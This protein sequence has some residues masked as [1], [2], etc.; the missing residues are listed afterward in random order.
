MFQIKKN[1]EVQELLNLEWQKVNYRII[2]PL[3]RITPRK[4]PM[5]A[6]YPINLTRHSMVTQF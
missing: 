2:V 1:V 6:N 5:M 3:L 4:V